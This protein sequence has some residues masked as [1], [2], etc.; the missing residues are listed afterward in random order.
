MHG[1]L[2]LSERMLRGVGDVKRLL[3]VGGS[4]LL[5]GN[6]SLMGAAEFEVIATYCSNEV[7]MENVDFL[8]LNLANV[9]EVSKIEH[10]HP[11]YVINCAALT[12]VDYCEEHPDEAYSVNVTASVRVAEAAKRCH[13]RL[14]HISTDAV[15]DGTKGDYSETDPAKPL[16]VYGRTK[17]EAEAKVLTVYPDSCVV[18]TN[19]YG[20]NKRAKDSLAEWMLNKLESGNELPALKDVFFSPIL[21]NDLAEHLFELMEGDYAGVIHVAGSETCSKLAFALLIADVFGFDRSLVKP[22]GL[23][24]LGLKAPRGRNTSLNVTKAEAIL[25][26]QMPTA[27]AGL[28]RMKHL[29]DQSYVRKLKND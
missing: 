27:K 15:F 12:N 22:I 3:V 24:E 19:I 10:A 9:D 29:L 6:L 1:A 13:A 4:G 7:D 2:R 20:W 16:S 25:G 28:T 23:D 18:R 14:V 17:L 21:V 5:G 26:R 11:D 8:Q